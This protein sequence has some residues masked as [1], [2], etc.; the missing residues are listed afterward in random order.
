MCRLYKHL[1][2]LCN[3]FNATSVMDYNINVLDISFD[4]IISVLLKHKFNKL[5]II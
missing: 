1:G 3:G 4:G 2:G 5:S